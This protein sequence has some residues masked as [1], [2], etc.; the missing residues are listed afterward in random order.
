[1]KTMPIVAALRTARLGLFCTCLLIA[2]CTPKMDW[3][4][5]RQETAGFKAMFPGK[6]LEVSRK[7]SLGQPP[8]A[9]TLTLQSARIDD[10]MFAVGWIDNARPGHR[11]Q[12]EEAM[13][14]NI[15]AVPDSIRRSSI[16]SA[17]RP[18]HELVARGM[19][20]L[21]PA[22]PLVEARLWMRTMDV[23]IEI[24]GMGKGTAKPTLRIIEAI[25]VGPASQANEEDAQQ[26]L[27]AFQLL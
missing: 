14:A 25:V 23:L 22:G 10:V 8:E 15:Q 9:I 16:G 26:F 21:D 1:M 4:E 2:G 6:P 19:M 3:R 17:G 13:L 18:A 5:I 11:Q 7:L 12:L 20:R 24:P 27:N